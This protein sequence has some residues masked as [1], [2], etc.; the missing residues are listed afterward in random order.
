[1]VEILTINKG[2]TLALEQIPHVRSVSIGFWIKSGSINEAEHENGISHFIEHMM[3]KGTKNRTA[4]EIAQEMDLI[5]GILNAFSSKEYTCYYAKVID[6]H[7]DLVIDIISDILINSTFPESEIEKEKLVIFEEM[8]MYEDSPEEIILDKFTEAI[9]PEHPLGRPILGKKKY[10]KKVQRQDILNFFSRYYTKKNLLITV[11][12]NFNQ[13]KLINLLQ[14]KLKDFPDSIENTSA[15]QNPPEYCQSIKVE[16]RDIE[17]VHV[18]IGGEGLKQTSEKRYV[19]NLLNIILGGGMSSRLF[20]QIRE[21][22]GLAY[23][24]HSFQSSYKTGGIFCI[25]FGGS[26]KNLNKIIYHIKQECEHLI[27]KGVLDTELN[28]AKEQLKGNLLL[29]L[30]NTSNRMTR[31]AKNIIYYNKHIEVDEIIEMIESVTSCDIQKLA[32]EIINFEK[33][34]LYAIGPV[35]KKILISGV[36]KL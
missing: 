13:N 18:C 32:T 16:K 23:V 35:N 25:Y 17:Q 22:L 6:Y 27:S 30:E 4:L 21:K 5:G 36:N 15:P 28:R 9:W 20:Q 8:K 19:L 33:F 26:A 24:I 12:G 1:M 2:I 31:L 34:S 10:I 29:S 3:F 14:K 7:I 11:A